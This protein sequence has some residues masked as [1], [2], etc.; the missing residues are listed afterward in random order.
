VRFKPNRISLL[1]KLRGAPAAVG[2]G[3]ETLGTVQLRLEGIDSIEKA[4]FQP[5]ATDSRDNLFA[6]IGKSDLMP[7]PA[8][9]ILSRMTDN[10]SRRPI[11]FA[12]AGNTLKADGSEVH[13]SPALLRQSVNYRQL[14]DGFA[15]PLY[16]NTLFSDLRLTF[17]EALEKA[18][19]ANAATG[20]W[21]KDASLTGVRVRRKED[22]ATIPPVWPKLWRRL[23]EY[24][25]TAN[26]LA[27]FIDFLEQKNE[28][29]DVLNVMEERGLQDL[30]AVK[31]N[32][33]RLLESPENLRIRAQ[34]GWVK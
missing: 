23:E 12:F 2:T 34:A 8:G 15:Y 20:I 11:A 5:L 1:D 14:L 25:R 18:R 3:A 13:L 28:R 22:L 19:S 21:P 27:G 9:Y 30:I 31:G 4:A 16:Y 6:L 32:K 33:V 29:I 10:K 26:S 17:D 24:F 7:A